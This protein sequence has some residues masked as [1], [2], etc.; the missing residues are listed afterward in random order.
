[1]KKWL[2]TLLLVLAL[3]P[4]GA[5]AAVEL[6]LTPGVGQVDYTFHAEECFVVLKYTAP[7]ETGC[8]TLYDA[9]GDFSGT[10]SLPLSGKGGRVKV[11]VESLAQRTL[12]SGTATL[13][14]DPACVTPTGT[15]R[16]KVK[17]LTLTETPEGLHYSF[18]AEGADYLTLSY[19]SRQESG[20]FYVYPVDEAGH[21][22]GDLALP[23]TYARTLVTVKVLSGAANATYAEAQARKGW[24]APAAPEVT[25]EGRLKGVVVCID[26]GHQEN[27]EYV[28]EPIGPGLPGSTTGKGGMARG[29]VTMRLEHIVTL[30]VAYLLRDELLRQGAQVVMTRTEVG[31]FISN[32]GR[33]AIATEGGAD[34][35]LRLHCDYR[36]GA[37]SKYG[38][39]VFMPRNSDYAKA[40]ATPEEWETMGQKLLDAM[41][42]AV[43]YPLDE[44]TGK[45]SRTDSYI[46]NNW[47]TMPCFL[48]EMGYMT[49]ARED[50]LLSAPVYQQWL[51]EGMAQGVYDIAVYRGLLAQDAE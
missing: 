31:P 40:L 20:S 37:P 26:A 6:T 29:S 43:G 25:G 46:G 17:S 7:A 4:C 30:E 9:D 28:N 12:A 49:N 2:L 10:L 50:V 8:L 22:E 3:V 34:I 13:P 5:R 48:V 41:R 19:K 27:G 32:L 45:I 36:S 15:G 1:M 35:M 11:T 14:E 44:K 24:A 38:I 51:A 47:A 23:M 16:A 18:T 33:C 21:F 39:S 42:T